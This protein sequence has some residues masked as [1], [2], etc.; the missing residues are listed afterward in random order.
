MEYNF[1]LNK[2]LEVIIY[3][4]KSQPG[5]NITD[6]IINKNINLIEE[7]IVGYLQ[8]WL[9]DNDLSEMNLYELKEYIV[10]L[11]TEKLKNDGNDT[12]NNKYNR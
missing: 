2:I 6:M 8:E 11:L 3:E 4:L 7:Y 12:A 9:Y 1:N 10:G 5:N